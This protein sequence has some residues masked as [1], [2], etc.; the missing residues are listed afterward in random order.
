VSSRCS[1]VLLPQE[2]HT[3]QYLPGSGASGLETALEVG[4]LRFE[5]LDPFRRGARRPGRSLERLYTRFRLKRAAAKCG[6]LV[7]EMADELL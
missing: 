2:S 4:V 7:A 6:K 1:F 5:S 3:I